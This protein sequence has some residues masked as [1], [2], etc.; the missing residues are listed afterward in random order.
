MVKRA[1][2]P[3]VRQTELCDEGRRVRVLVVDDHELVR[4]GLRILIGNE[5]NLEVCGA[6]ATDIEAQKLFRRLQPDVVVVDLT[7]QDDSGLD[8][9][10]WIKKPQSVTKVVVSTMHDELFMDQRDSWGLVI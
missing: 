10:K 9:I 4:E 8:L 3:A 2:K 6:T 5:P 1:V 7:L